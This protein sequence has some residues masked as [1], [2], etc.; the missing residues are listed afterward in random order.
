MPPILAF[1]CLFHFVFV[2]IMAVFAFSLI[3]EYS[4][5]KQLFSISNMLAY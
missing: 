3:P 2:G 5:Q 4:C 1:L